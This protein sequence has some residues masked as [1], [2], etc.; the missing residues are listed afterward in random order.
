LNNAATHERTE[1]KGRRPAWLDPARPFPAGLDRPLFVVDFF[2]GCG[3]TSEGLR[4]AGF[5]I[6]AAVDN[7]PAT[8][9]TYRINFP[10][11]MFF[12][13]DIRDL[14]E[15]DV[16]R[17][18]RDAGYRAGEAFLSFAAC[19]PCQPFSK[20]RR[21]GG[22][23]D[24]R[25]D[26]LSELLRFVEHLQPHALIIENVPGLQQWAGPT[27]T[28]PSF[29]L[30]IERA[31]Y[32]IATRIVSSQ[33][34]GTPQRR[35]RLVLIASRIGAAAIPN[36]TFGPGLRPYAT[37]RS[38]IGDLPPISAGESHPIVSNHRAARLSPLNLLRIRSTPEGGGRAD[39]PAELLVPC[40]SRG[41]QGHTDVYGRLR[42]DAPAPALTTRCISYSNGRFGHP[43]QDRALSVREAA[44]LQTFPDDFRFV[45]ALSSQ[46]RQV[47]NA[48]PVVLAR[49]LGES[50]V[51]TLRLATAGD[52]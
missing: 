15:S 11:V 8:A 35:R 37:V 39:W 49:A 48:V 5:V 10:G 22:S 13:Q 12:G 18:V 9:E 24:D 16:Q 38:A 25:V 4:Q 1:S 43:K 29:C 7:D 23:V 47:G 31:G 32:D 3:G 26:L 20:Q 36:P 21:S 28:Y 40:H 52:D 41:F 2:S 17:A 19:A 45:G 27:A 6:A 33:S 14:R 30:A 44:R 42:W 46:A 50:L 51:Q 34:Y